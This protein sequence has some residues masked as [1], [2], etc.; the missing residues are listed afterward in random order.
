MQASA[1]V[2]QRFNQ[3]L[4]MEHI[5][6]PQ[7][8]DGEV[9]VRVEAAGIC[10]SDVHMW[11]GQD[12]R[13]PLPIILGHEGAGRIC[14]LNGPRRDINGRTLEV[15]QHVLWERGVSCGMCH[16]CQVLHTP[17][18]CPKRWAYGIHRSRSQPPYLVGAYATHMVLD[19]GTVF[20]P[21]DEADDPAVMVM[22]SCSGA[23]AA[24]AFDMTLQR[25]GDTCIIF[26]P[27]PLGAFA[28]ALARA[29]GAEQIMVVGGNHARL[30]L[31]RSLGATHLYDR[32]QLSTA[33]L[34]AAVRKATHGRGADLAVEASGS[35]DAMLA[36]LEVLRP[37]GTLLM[38]GMGEPVGD[39]TL[40][41]FELIVRKNVTVQGCWVSDT[42]HTHQAISLIRQQPEA[43]AALVTHRFPLNEATQALQAVKE[44]R[45]LKAVLLP[46]E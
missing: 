18:L 9:L 17:S 28:V 2:L 23:T 5:S 32:H 30:E 6:I 1:V 20:F 37:G 26:G 38:P 43:M 35:V 22:A 12:P 7:L 8:R 34:T 42:R 25:P 11:R 27:G 39:A 21:L 10:G 29:G 36:G 46:Q 31:C 4:V 15:G 45:A 16:Y 24:H 13:T 44:R 40:P 3:P 19:A 14:Q 33:D 41:P